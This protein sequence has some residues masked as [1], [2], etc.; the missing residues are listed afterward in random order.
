MY[1]RSSSR[2]NSDIQIPDHYSGCAFGKSGGDGAPPRYLE[3]A[4]PSPPLWEEAEKEQTPPP[5]PPLPPSP[6]KPTS[7]L[8]SKGL[9]FDQLLILGLILLLWGSETDSDIVLW[10]A[11]LLL[12]S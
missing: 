2:R 11:L 5:H 7:P 6:S 9:E 10:L 4:K 12:W 8:F 3:V 1:S